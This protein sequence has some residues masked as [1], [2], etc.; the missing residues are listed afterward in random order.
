MRSV[1]SPSTRDP[2][3]DRLTAETRGGAIEWEPMALDGYYVAS[4]RRNRVYFLRR[5]AEDDEGD[6]VP[7]GRPIPI[8]LDV[9]D[10]LGNVL[11]SRRD[12]DERAGVL[13]ELFDAVE[14]Y[15]TE[16]GGLIGSPRELTAA[17]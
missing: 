5:L 13:G 3:A 6:P 8:L 11:E 10:G 16:R 12:D 4:T 9:K 7:D 2:L 17:L 14:Q 15:L 1:A